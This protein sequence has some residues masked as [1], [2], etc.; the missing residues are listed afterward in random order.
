VYVVLGGA[1]ILFS[2]RLLDLLVADQSLYV[3]LQTAKG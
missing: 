1:W 2:D 3:A